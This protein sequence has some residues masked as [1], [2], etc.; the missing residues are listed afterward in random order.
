MGERERRLTRRDFIRM[1]A[2]A[3]LGT[4]VGAEVLA[5]EEGP[6]ARMARVVLVRDEQAVA[7]DGQLNASVMAGG[8]S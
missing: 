2:Y 5:G 7:G 8:A 3:A 4:A 6:S 1:A